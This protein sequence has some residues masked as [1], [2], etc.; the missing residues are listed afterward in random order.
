MSSA[1]RLL[2]EGVPE[3]AEEIRGLVR[4][5]VLVTDA[6]SSE[7]RSFDGASTFYLWGAVLLNVEDVL[8]SF[9][10]SGRLISI[11]NSRT[12]VRGINSVPIIGTNRA[13]KTISTRAAR[14]TIHLKFHPF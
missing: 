13:D 5:I 1:L 7:T 8:S 2:D 11:S 6:K 3:L 14:I 4:E 10:P 9:V 12:S